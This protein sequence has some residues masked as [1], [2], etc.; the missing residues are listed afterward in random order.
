MHSDSPDRSISLDALLAESPWLRRLARRLVTGED[1]AEDLAQD[2]LTAALVAAPTIDGRPLRHWLGT[3]AR[4]RASRV[5]ARVRARTDAEALAATPETVQGEPSTHDRLALHRELAEAIAALDPADRDLIVWRYFDERD[6]AWIGARL[7]VAPATARK[8]ISRALQR[9]RDSLAS[10]GRGAEGWTLAL[11]MI[12]RLPGSSTPA[13]LTTAA[14]VGAASTAALLTAMTLTKLAAAAALIALVALAF[15][16]SPSENPGGATLAVDHAEE[17]SLMDGDLASAHP[18]A[19][20]AER[21]SPVLTAPSE[22]H[23]V[24]TEPTLEIT[25]RVMDER[26]RP[27]EGARVQLFFGTGE[28]RESVS[29]EEGEYRLDSPGRSAPEDRFG[30]VFASLSGGLAG[31]AYM[32]VYGDATRPYRAPDVI[33]RPGATDVEV[34]VVRNGKPMAG[35]EV[36][37]DAGF[38]RLI[39][40]R[41]R[42]NGDGLANFESVPAG[43]LRA[44]VRTDEAVGAAKLLSSERSPK[45]VLRVTLE[46]ARTV[47]VYVHDASDESVPL[48][49]IRITAHEQVMPSRT[50]G[51]SEDPWI[52]VPN[53]RPILGASAVTDEAGVALIRGLPAGPLWIHEAPLA[54]ESW[55]DSRVRVPDASAE[56][57]LPVRAMPGRDRVEWPLAQDELTASIPDG[58]I[59][60]LRPA[61]GAYRHTPETA[62]IEHRRVVVESPPDGFTGALAESP[63]GLMAEL[64]V[65]PT[66]AEGLEVNFVPAREITVTVRNA[67]GTPAEGWY[68]IAFNQGNHPMKDAI[69]TG[70]DGVAELTG[71]HGRLVDVR[72]GRTIRGYDGLLAG[73]VDLEAGGAALEFTLPRI[74]ELILRTSI[75]GVVQLPS[76][77][78][79]FGARVI[80]D[81][82]LAGEIRIA[83]PLAPTATSHSLW[84]RGGADVL[85]VNLVLTPSDLTGES[86][87]DVA[88]QRAGAILASVP[89]RPG[90][91][92]EIAAEGRRED[93]TWVEN[94]R[95]FIDAPNWDDDLFRFAP[96]FP[97]T[98]RLRD[99]KS[100]TATEPFEVLPGSEPTRITLDL[101][102]G[103]VVRGRVA[104]PRGGDMGAAR[105]VIDS[106]SDDTPLGTD[107][108]LDAPGTPTNSIQVR[109]DG[110]FEVATQAGKVLTLTAWHSL[111]RAAEDGGSVRLT[112]PAEGVELQLTAAPTAVVRLPEGIQP[113][114]AP[115]RRVLL[116]SSRVG[117]DATADEIVAAIEAEHVLLPLE[118]QDLAFGGFAPGRYSVW[119]DTGHAVA[120]LLLADIELTDGANDLTWAEFPAGSSLDFQIETAQGTS[121]PRIAPSAWSKARM[122]SGDPLIHRSMNSRGETGVKLT[123]LWKGAYRV[124]CSIVAERISSLK[125]VIDQELELDGVTSVPLPVDLVER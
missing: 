42:T 26:R 115:S 113:G 67:D 120:P 116:L 101:T 1:G 77:Y 3:V 66:A 56:V 112:G 121:P 58:T 109:G 16:R 74:A 40:G 7:D 107:R 81:D 22:A 25:G 10:S 51:T 38:G 106:A 95:D 94:S 57:K 29:D 17:A 82:P 53:I 39:V 99:L 122:P 52:A 83:V 50:R 59:L 30:S 18:S 68:V 125:T 96:L 4:R 14:P 37:L 6:A 72:V 13:P 49:G 88:F 69:P 85:A 98:Y 84:L 65:A 108:Y 102:Q 45:S 5:R 47:K 35:A 2:V 46:P 64:R 19:D 23:P 80:G 87:I 20:Q 32:S 73:S 124:R 15:L 54:G 61:P 86:P 36:A 11:V 103:G 71:L 79:V 92:V 123:G 21:T 110:T 70:P 89:R 119:I 97:A 43:S 34:Q 12:A 114:R 41:G 78:T 105:V 31:C 27:V 62:R 111:L 8:R 44:V 24:D 60:S 91:R 76:T 118:G 63:Q 100:G 90:I 48:A 55:S 9:L 117:A 104:L 75:D 93:G 28:T 33:L